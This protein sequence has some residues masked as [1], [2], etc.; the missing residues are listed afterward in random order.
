MTGLAAK[1]D[2]ILAKLHA[3]TEEWSQNPFDF[4]VFV[5]GTILGTTALGGPDHRH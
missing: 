3:N 1:T 5:T 2:E 4:A